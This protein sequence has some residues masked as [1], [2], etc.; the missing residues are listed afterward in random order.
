MCIT[1]IESDLDINK[2]YNIKKNNNNKND[3]LK[4]SHIDN[5]QTNETHIYSRGIS[6]NFL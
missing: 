3:V 1:K 2:F 4:K 6:G 5:V